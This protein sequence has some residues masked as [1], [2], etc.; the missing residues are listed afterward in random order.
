MKLYDLYCG[1]F[2]T[3]VS[4]ITCVLSYQLGLRSIRN[5]GPGLIPFGVAAI[6]GFMS[7]GLSVRGLFGSK[8]GF[9]SGPVFKGV[10][11][12]R[13]VVALGGL[14]GY[15]MTFNF[16]GFRLCTFSLMVLLLGV[17]GRQK[18]WLTFTVSV[19][20]VIFAHLIFVVWLGCPFP[21]GPLGI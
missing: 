18:W 19:I 17:V 14:L 11:W 2:L 12:R 1:A 8:N 21:A 5:P 16:L 13:V 20:T 3:G 15:G 6:L 7:I 9:Q 10:N 4:G